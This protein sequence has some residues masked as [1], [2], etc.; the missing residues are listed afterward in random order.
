MITG[1]ERE[2]VDKKNWEKGLQREEIEKALDHGFYFLKENGK[3][4]EYMLRS[5]GEE[6]EESMKGI[7]YWVF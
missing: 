4:A 5:W 7:R 6:E 1:E 3:E 2:I